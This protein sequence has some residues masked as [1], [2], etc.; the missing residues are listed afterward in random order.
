ML[1]L[2]H[3]PIYIHIYDKIVFLIK[4]SF[5]LFFSQTNPLRISHVGNKS[6]LQ[7]LVAGEGDRKLYGVIIGSVGKQTCAFGCLFL[8]RSVMF[9]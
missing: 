2:Q 7:K 5:S 8:T 4:F 1:V 6:F 9:L 3:I